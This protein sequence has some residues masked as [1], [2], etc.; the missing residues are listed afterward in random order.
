MNVVIETFRMLSSPSLPTMLMLFAGI[1]VV[2]ADIL[3]QRL[4]RM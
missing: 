2:G 3:A 1:I 4:T